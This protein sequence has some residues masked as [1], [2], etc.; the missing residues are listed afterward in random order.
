MTAPVASCQLNGSVAESVAV[1]AVV[2][3][4]ALFIARMLSV[5]R[6]MIWSA[7]AFQVSLLTRAS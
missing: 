5:I 7:P 2:Y 1:G 6:A 4:S 3:H